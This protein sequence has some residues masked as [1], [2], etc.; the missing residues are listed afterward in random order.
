MAPRP[1][2]RRFPWARRADAA[3]LGHDL[4]NTAAKPE[5][6]VFGEIRCMSSGFEGRSAAADQPSHLAFSFGLGP[7]LT[8]APSRRG[9]GRGRLALAR[10][11]DRELGLRIQRLKYDAVALG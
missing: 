8:T 2:R 7:P 4:E 3:P 10:E 9:S 5:L 11:A 6:P 1:V